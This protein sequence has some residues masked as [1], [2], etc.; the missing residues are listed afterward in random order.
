MVAVAR[1][2]SA[3][4]VITS[5][6]AVSFVVVSFV[7][8]EPVTYLTH[9]FVMHGLGMFL[10]RSHHRRWPARRPHDPFFEAND[11]FPVVFASITVSAM[12][13]AFNVDGLTVLL[14]VGVGVTAYGGAYA[15]VH[16]GFIHQRLRVGVRNRWLDHLAWAHGL[17]HRFGAEPYG[18]LVP[19]VPA[20]LRAKAAAAD[21]RS[22]RTVSGLTGA[23][24]QATE[25]IGPV[26]GP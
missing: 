26:P 15:F 5:L 3:R 16:D 23:S 6:S 11:A 7:I 17:H 4:P 21:E 20:S 8:M 9:R 24:S 12:A 13:V 1:I 10:H 14:P 18:M 19:V 22:A 25:R 2:R